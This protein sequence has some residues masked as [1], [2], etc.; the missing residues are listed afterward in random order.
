MTKVTYG[1]AGDRDGGWAH[2]TF[3]WPG[4][5]LAQNVRSMTHCYARGGVALQTAPYISGELEMSTRI[6]DDNT[7]GGA[8]LMGLVAGGAI[9]AGLALYCFAPRLISDLRQRLAESTT[10]L[11][12]AASDGVRAVTTRTADV[13]ETV[14]D[15]AD[16]VT[17]KG[18]EI[19]DDMADVV[20][21]SANEVGRGA[22]AVV[23]GARDVEQ[24]ATASKNRPESDAIMTESDDDNFSPRAGRPALAVA[25]LA[26]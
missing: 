23:R 10:D 14:A 8:F 11:R 15:V 21:R 5:F 4:T 25:P 13:V 7:H 9:G 3:R 2:K 12:S 26:R 1:R 16:Q 18:Q 19:R 22:R 17:R 24:F 20:A 6:Q